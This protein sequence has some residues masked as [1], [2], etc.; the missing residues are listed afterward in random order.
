MLND[1][2]EEERYLRFK[3]KS[4]SH[5]KILPGQYIKIESGE[6]SRYFVIS[7]WINSENEF[8]IIAN[9]DTHFS[10]LLKK[11]I[12]YSNPLGSGYDISDVD[13]KNII[14][15]AGGAGIA[16]IRPLLQ[17]LN[18]EKNCKNHN[19]IYLERDEKHFILKEEIKDLIPHK[20]E[21][22]FVNT[23]DFKIKNFLNYS[24]DKF[25]IFDPNQIIDETIIYVC[26]NNDLFARVH[27]EF[28]SLG[29]SPN[30]IRKNF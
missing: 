29:V 18:K 20:Y 13:G 21:F 10:K 6:E 1:L 25:R 14:Y 23:S 7:N 16:G 9:K 28:T 17:Y 3:L 24:I 5:G 2:L 22:S 8:E 26:G 11:K 30:N 4:N 15:I 19:L 12:E 27:S